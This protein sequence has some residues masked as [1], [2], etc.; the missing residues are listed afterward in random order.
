MGLLS[1]RFEMDEK[2]KA[3][4]KIFERIIVVLAFMQILSPLITSLCCLIGIQMDMLNVMLLVMISFLIVEVL[5]LSFNLIFIQ[6]KKPNLFQ[7]FAMIMALWLI[8][9][10]LV[11]NAVN[12]TFIFYL[13]YMLCF[14]MFV[15][16]DKKHYKW[17]MF[18]FIFVMTICSIMGLIDP[19]NNFM[20]G[21]S[22]RYFPMS[23]QFANS[24]YASYVTA[25]AIL[26]CMYVIKN[27]NKIWE[28]IVF[29]ICF[30][31]L[32]FTIFV[33]GCYAGE[34]AVFIA[35]FFLLLFYWIKNKKCPW[36]IIGCF[37]I[38]VI[39]SFAFILFPNIWA[40]SSA[41]AN[42]FYE[43]LA[44]MDNIFGTT[45][46]RDSSILFSGK[47]IEKVLGA[48]G[49]D[50]GSYVSDIWGY[51]FHSPLTFL[52]GYGAG[53]NY[54]VLVHNV[55]LQMLL[56][57][58]FIGLAL[59]LTLIVLF[60]IAFI[61]NLRKLD[62]N[63]IFLFAIFATFVLIIHNFGPLESYSFIYF[64]MLFAVLYKNRNKTESVETTEKVEVKEKTESKEEGANDGAK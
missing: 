19:L 24:N 7:I 53:K 18:V 4:N 58:G 15:K 26:L 1:A 22:K 25:L 6:W 41:S 59:Y 2:D 30:A 61:K 27:Y 14:V 64:M 13:C 54:E 12:F 55:Y 49:Y 3:M 57:I 29:W 34:F 38:S 44:I 16:I 42:F 47:E 9:V 46:L 33:N 62:D 28:Q 48:D 36:K 40:A 37:A 20:P 31:I 60:A 10:A 23:L 35:E 45:F 52:F 5:H 43:S 17:L 8:L 51:V 21:F 32:N 11:N 50:R 56:E 63:K 39:M